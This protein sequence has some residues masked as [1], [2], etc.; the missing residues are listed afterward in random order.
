[1]EYLSEI[2]GKTVYDVNGRDIG[3][4]QDLELSLSED[5]VFLR[6]KGEPL[7][8]I[9]GRMKEFLPMSEID[10]VDGGVH[11]YKTLDEVKGILE[12]VFMSA[13]HSHKCKDLV[14]RPVTSNED[15]IGRVSDFGI[16][17]EANQVVMLVEGPRI[18]EVF[19]RRTERIPI[20]DV[21]EI[22][23]TIR[24]QH[25]VDTLSRRIS[26]KREA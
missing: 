22:V 25:D 6:V 15:E 2:V 26:E 24:L 7:K 18:R 23:E 12:D 9:R 16:D 20:I 8:G 11:L 14:G 4:A 13:V 10:Y 21:I 1:M 17:S 5:E 19:G 3:V